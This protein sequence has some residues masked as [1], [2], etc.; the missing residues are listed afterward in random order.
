MT[1]KALYAI[2]RRALLSG[3]NTFSSD[4]SFSTNTLE[5]SITK[6]GGSIKGGA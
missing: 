2:L 5:S 3:K 4:L 1:L 6:S